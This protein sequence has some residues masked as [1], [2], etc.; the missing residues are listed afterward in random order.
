MNI[1]Q[2]E[3]QSLKDAASEAQ[4]NEVCDRIKE[5]RAG[6]YPPPTGGQK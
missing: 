3:L 4:W 2:Q 1:T 6:D 5:A